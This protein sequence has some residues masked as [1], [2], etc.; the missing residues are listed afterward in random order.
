MLCL[1]WCLFD[2]L[3]LTR[4]TGVLILKLVMVLLNIII[5]PTSGVLMAVLAVGSRG[6]VGLN[7]YLYFNDLGRDSMVAL[8][9]LSQCYGPV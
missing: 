4:Q 8:V 3:D 7:L 2:I 1:L 6:R 9:L 5:T